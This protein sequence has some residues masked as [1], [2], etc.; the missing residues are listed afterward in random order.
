MKSLPFHIPEACK[1]YL[2]WAKPPHIGH[3][4]EYTPPPP[5]G[6]KFIWYCRKRG[7]HHSPT[8]WVKSA[9]EPYSTSCQSTCR[10]H[11]H[12]ATRSISTPPLLLTRMLVLC[13]LIPCTKFGVTHFVHWGRVRYCESILPKNTTQCPQPELKLRWL[14]PKL[15]PTDHEA[16]TPPQVVWQ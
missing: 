7:Q 2:F 6:C 11:W 4:R 5:P 10:Y 15:R 3:Y 9:Y 12:E 13:R 14:D 8:T 1:R 16:A